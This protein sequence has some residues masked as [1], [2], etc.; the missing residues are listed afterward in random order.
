MGAAARARTRFDGSCCPKGD[1]PY[2]PGAVQLMRVTKIA[3]R[4]WS[5]VL[6]QRASVRLVRP[7]LVCE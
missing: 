3:R 1:M 5:S 4:Y 7:G 6:A 2:D